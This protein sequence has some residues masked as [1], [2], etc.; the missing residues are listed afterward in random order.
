MLDRNLIARAR[1]NKPLVG[2]LEE[3]MLKKMEEMRLKT[4]G[5]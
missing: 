4:E 3:L 2:Y 5:R 1:R